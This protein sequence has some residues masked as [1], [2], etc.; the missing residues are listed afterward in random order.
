[1][2]SHQAMNALT[3]YIGYDAREHEAYEVCRHSLERHASIPLNIKV[4][5]HKTLRSIG[6]YDRPFR[7]ESTQRVDDR[8]GRPFSTD[9]AFT[10]FL[11]PAL[12]L[13]SDWALF[14]DCDFLFT[15]DVAELVA[16]RDP[17]KAMSVVKHVYMPK[18]TT[19]MDGQSQGVYPRKNWSSLMLWNCG[20]PATKN[21]TVQAVNHEGGKWLHGLSW[22]Q[23]HEIG[24][25]PQTW[26]WLCGVNDLPEETPAAIHFTLGTPVMPGYENQPYADLWRQELASVHAIPASERLSVAGTN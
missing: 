1:M 11:V 22:L 21:I 14:V 25:I 6:V 23:D 26:N 5:D 18:E 24:E 12:S 16:C 10:R 8:D 13:Y 15:R 19:K 20:H 3:V 2:G 4:L 7:V 9:F 17:I